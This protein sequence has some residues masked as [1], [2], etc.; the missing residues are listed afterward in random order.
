MRLNLEIELDWIDDE[1][2][3]DETIRQ[4]VIDTVVSKIQKN[5][6][7]KVED[8]INMTIDERIL[9]KIDEMTENLF[10]NFL[11]KEVVINDKYGDVLKTYSS[12][13]E[14]IKERFDN[15]LTQQVDGMSEY[16]FVEALG[17]ELQWPFFTL[18]LVKENLKAKTQIRIILSRLQFYIF[19]ILSS[20]YPGR[21]AD[22]F[23]SGLRDAPTAESHQVQIASGRYFQLPLRTSQSSSAKGHNRNTRSTN[24]TLHRCARQIR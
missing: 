1:M 23:C 2:N 19:R 7:S 5:V 12:V 24:R 8:K 13:N 3:V 18:D 4:N 21:S 11:N 17:G 10:N 22:I 9:S 6:E 15:F 14:M 16:D 20:P